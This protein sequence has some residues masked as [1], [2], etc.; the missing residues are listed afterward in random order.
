M[1]KL[2][3]GLWR[4]QTPGLDKCQHVTWQAFTIQTSSIFRPLIKHLQM[5]VHNFI[6]P[7]LLEV[8]VGAWMHSAWPVSYKNGLLTNLAFIFLCVYFSC[9]MGESCCKCQLGLLLQEMTTK[10]QATADAA[11]IVSSNWLHQI[12]TYSECYAYATYGS[13]GDAETWS[14]KSRNLLRQLSFLTVPRRKSTM[15]IYQEDLE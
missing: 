1:Q 12:R 4:L 11:Q 5:C 13:D 6:L 14:D 2:D 8:L 7:G 9:K 3:F 10:W 15:K